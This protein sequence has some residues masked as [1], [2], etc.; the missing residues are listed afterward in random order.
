MLQSDILLGVALDCS[1]KAN[2]KIFVKSNAHSDCAKLV[3]TK[4]RKKKKDEG[5]INRYSFHVPL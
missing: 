1:I 3:Y 2:K 5:E 4:K